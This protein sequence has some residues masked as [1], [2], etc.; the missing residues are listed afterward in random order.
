MT[1]LMKLLA[2]PYSIK[3]VKF[4]P[5]AVAS[6]SALMVMFI[7]ARDIQN[8]LDSIFGIDGWQFEVQPIAKSD[9]KVAS[10][11]GK[12]SVKLGDTWVTKSDV[13]E[14]S[15]NEASYKDAVSDALKRC[16]VHFGIF[17]YAYSLKF[18]WSKKVGG[19]SEKYPKFENPVIPYDFLPESDK[20]CEHCGEHIPETVTGNKG[21]VDGGVA[22]CKSYY[23][24]EQI[25]CVS[26]FSNYLKNKRGD[27]NGEGHE[28]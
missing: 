15:Q 13:G 26:C 1:E 22:I 8:R 20:V 10:A 28:T 11:V 2:E 17:R 6:N 23:A 18:P 7:D 14:A 4:K 27:G 21:T 5:Q 3:S 16:A 12:L 24:T 19:G 25:L 9:S